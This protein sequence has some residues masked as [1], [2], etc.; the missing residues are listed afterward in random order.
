[1]EGC[2]FMYDKNNANEIEWANSLIKYLRDIIVN[3]LPIRKIP[4]RILK[5]LY[6]G[7]FDYVFLVHARRSQDLF[8]SIP[9]LSFIRKRMGKR[10]FLNLMSFLPSKAVSCLESEDGIRGLVLVSS[11]M[12]EIIAGRRQKSLKEMKSMVKFAEKV[13]NNGKVV[14]G[15]GGWW[16]IVTSRGR[17]LEKLVNNST[18]SVTTGHTATILSILLMVEKISCVSKIDMRKLKVLIIGAGK[19]GSQVA[20]ALIENGIRQV[21]LMDINKMKMDKI[22]EVLYKRNVKIEKVLIDNDFKNKFEVLDRHHMAICATSSSGRV[23]KPQ[24]IPENYII[25]D[26][27]RPEAI[28]RITK[29]NSKIILEGGL[30]KINGLINDYDY[31]FGK[32]SNVFGCCCESYMLAKDKKQSI[33]ATIGDVDLKNLNNYKIFCKKNNIEVGDFKSGKK[34]IDLK[35]IKKVMKEREEIVSGYELL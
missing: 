12:P 4:D 14:I 15:L 9:A 32:D 2:I 8:V 6:G 23:I 30:L 11:L 19:I 22:C 29:S 26:D 21:T 28:S 27:S 7:T 31:G 24:D 25:I 10:K 35:L 16:P 18:V 20:K 5:V 33:K 13:S 1:M 17:F 3:Y 34:I